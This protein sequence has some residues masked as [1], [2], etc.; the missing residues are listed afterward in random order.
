MR[1]RV[2]SY[3]ESSTST[4][5]PGVMRMRNRRRRPARLARIVWPFSSS[6]LNVELGNVSTTRPTRLSV[7]SLTTGVRGSRRFLPP[8]PLRLR[9]G[10]MG[11]PS[12]GPR[13]VYGGSVRP[14]GEICPRALRRRLPRVRAW[15]AKQ[16][17]ESGGCLYQSY[18][19]K[20]DRIRHGRR[21]RRLH[22]GLRHQP[23]QVSDSRPPQ[24]RLRYPYGLV[25]NG[26]GTKSVRLVLEC[27]GR[28]NP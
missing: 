26:Y 25:T 3:G 16:L 19:N 10:G 4:S 21:R 27:S 18:D 20:R 1:P 13:W 2:R 22:L 24:G 5:S 9:G 8:P 7:S 11:A 17:P 28:K 12:V 14:R 6:T 15:Y 23:K